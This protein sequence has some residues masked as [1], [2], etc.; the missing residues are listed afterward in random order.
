MSPQALSRLV[1][2]VSVAAAALIIVS[3]VLNLALGLA[4][5][6]QSANSPLHTLKYS[7]AL[8][9]MYALL[10]ALTGLYLRQA[11]AAGKLGLIGYLIA[12][13]GTLMIAGDWWFESFIAPQLAAVAPEVMSGAI[14]GSMAIG[15]AATFGL[16]AV[17]WIVFGIATFRANVFPRPAAGLLI[18]GGLVGIL[19]GSTPYQVPLA[20]AVGWIG[21]SLMGF[22]QGTAQVASPT[23]AATH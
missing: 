13:L 6:A 1:G 14:T 8:L 23:P 7:V 11:N 17:G 12:F 19:A 3:Q 16:F 10:L 15:A 4:L 2:P 18:L 5:G 9:A 20:I 21:L 22:Q